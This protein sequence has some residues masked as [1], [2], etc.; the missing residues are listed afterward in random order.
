MA[1]IDHLNPPTGQMAP[2]GGLPRQQ[3]GYQFI[4]AAGGWAVQASPDVRTACA[5]CAGPPRTVYFLA[6]NGPEARYADGGGA[7]SRRERFRYASRTSRHAQ[8]GQ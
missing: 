1:T 3:S 4:P 8:L 5:S 6:D 2:I 7:R